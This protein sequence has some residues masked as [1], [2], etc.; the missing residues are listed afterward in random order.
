MIS[1]ETLT[2]STFD[3]AIDSCI[4]NATKVEG[5]EQRLRDDVMK[6]T[7]I[8]SDLCKRSQRMDP[9]FQAFLVLMENENDGN[10]RRLMMEYIFRQ[11]FLIGWHARGAIEESRE[12]NLMG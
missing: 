6:E 3:A 5:G 11:S 4:Q 7:L 2:L 12:L 9:I 1:L 10:R 8:L